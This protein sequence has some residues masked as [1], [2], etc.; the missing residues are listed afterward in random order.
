LTFL[1]PEL[2]DPRGSEDKPPY[3]ISKSNSDLKVA[4]A[5]AAAA[6]R[7]KTPPNI[8]TDSRHNREEIAKKSRATRERNHRFM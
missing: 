1:L 6:A 2:V 7:L 8:R 3:R 5:A 4:A